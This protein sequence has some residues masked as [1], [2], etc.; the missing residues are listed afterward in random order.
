MTLS[1][2]LGKIFTLRRTILVILAILIG[3]FAYI[4][5]WKMLFDNMFYGPLAAWLD[6]QTKEGFILYQGTFYSLKT[7][8]PLWVFLYPPVPLSIPLPPP[9]TDIIWIYTQP[10]TAVI[11]ENAQG[12]APILLFLVASAGTG[13]PDGILYTAFT[14]GFFALGR[15]FQ[16]VIQ[17]YT[18]SFIRFMGWG[19]GIVVTMGVMGLIGGFFAQFQVYHIMW[20]NFLYS[21]RKIKVLFTWIFSLLAPF[22]IGVLVN[23]YF[24]S[25]SQ[26]KFGPYTIYY[27]EVLMLC[28]I[29]AFVFTAL[30]AFFSKRFWSGALIGGTISLA[31]FL[32]ILR[33]GAPQLLRGLIWLPFD[34]T[35]QG[36]IRVSLSGG[37]LQADL[38]VAYTAM[39][40]VF[41][42][43]SAL[44]G[45]FWASMGRVSSYTEATPELKTPHNLAYIFRD[46]WSN[47]FLFGKNAVA[48][49][50]KK[51]KGIEAGLRRLFG[52]EAEYETYEHMDRVDRGGKTRMPEP[53]LEITARDEDKCMVRV[54]KTGEEIGPLYDPDYLAHKYKPAWNPFELAYQANIVKAITPLIG[55]LIAIATVY[56][57]FNIQSYLQYLLLP[58]PLWRFVTTGEVRILVAAAMVLYVFIVGFSIYWGIKSR[59]ILRES[60]EGAPAVIAIGIFTSAAYIFSEYI[61]L[62]L[63]DF[64]NINILNSPFFRIFV[65]GNT[66][67][68]WLALYASDPLIAL[69]LLWIGV[70]IG[71]PFIVLGPSLLDQFTLISAIPFNITFNA[72]LYGIAFLLVAAFILGLAGIQVL[73]FERVT[74][75]FYASEGP[76]FPYAHHDDAPVWVEGKYY[77]VLRFIYVWPGEFT[78][79]SKSLYHE[80]YERVEIWVNAE[81][82]LAEWIVSDYHWRE[83]FYRIPDDGKD[84]RIIVD[85]N[86]NF[87]TPNF[88]LLHPNEFEGLKIEDPFKA[89]FSM[90]SDW[91]K[92]AR[93]RTRELFKQL[94]EKISKSVT[95]KEIAYAVKTRSEYVDDYLVDIA[96]GVRRVAANV[97]AKLPWSFWRYPLGVPTI[98]PKTGK[99]YYREN[100]Y[101]PPK[102]KDPLYPIK[103]RIDGD[104]APAVI[105]KHVC[106]KCHTINTIDITSSAAENWQ[107]KK[108]GKDMRKLSLIH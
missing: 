40:A 61:M 55:V 96:P 94:G 18:L 19:F 68:P 54:R 16:D 98:N 37:V 7:F 9:Y 57:Y 50:T 48:E 70:S 104:G 46:L 64:L 22:A 39:A 3:V 35:T 20:K 102:I 14:S 88:I 93:D 58:D 99:Y 106:P 29:Y 21:F 12:V 2:K 87:H 62:R 5:Y 32:G 84:H 25:Q 59:H 83:L 108:C 65:L 27:N 60:P 86:T 6:Y 47:Y 91:L 95:H 26:L 85:F 76:L 81:T 107:C 24:I 105:N 75:Y 10:F 82:G 97:C 43:I 71:N 90:S 89:A 1:D 42:V 53:E 28:F 69:G 51:K 23:V 77:W 34:V 4:D 17:I 49:F 38:N 15:H 101:I 72:C 92:K 67:Q 73:G 13:L 30:S 8:T 33:T 44:W 36:I 41:I 74:T 66:M 31:A 79:A 63:A 45:G 56:F 11:Q 80:D 103:K 100:K 52:R 78:V